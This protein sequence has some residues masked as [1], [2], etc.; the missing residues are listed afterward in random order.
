MPQFALIFRGGSVETSGLSPSEMQ[1][2]LRKWY[3]WSDALAAAG[4]RSG[5][6]PL[7]AV[8]KTLRG[9]DRLVTDGPY[10]E[11]KDLVT[12]VLTISADSLDEAAVLARDCP[13][14]EL[15]GSVEVRPVIELRTT[16]E[17]V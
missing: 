15:G 10:A 16:L 1:A 12:G 7:E 13:V 4:R 14:F 2:H 17:N 11:A 6:K 9:K 3:E 5:G 8:G